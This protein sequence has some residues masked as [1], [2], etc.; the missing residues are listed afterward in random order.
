ML[1]TTVRWVAVT[2]MGLG[3]V[4]EC[5][6]MMQTFHLDA[7]WTAPVFEHSLCG[8]CRPPTYVILSGIVFLAVAMPSCRPCNRGDRAFL[9]GVYIFLSG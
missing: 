2:S 4:S 5:L 3:Y 7:V 8:F 9:R 1:T 6:T